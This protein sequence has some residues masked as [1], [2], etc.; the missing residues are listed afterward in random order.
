MTYSL[1]LRLTIL[2]LEQRLFTD[3]ETFMYFNLLAS[4]TR[5]FPSQNCD[6]IK[7]RCF[8][9]ELTC[10]GQNDRAIIRDQHGVFP[11]SGQRTIG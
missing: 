7:N 3:A 9:P 2:H 4:L 1:P 6:Y 8:C 11:M 5:T 10:L